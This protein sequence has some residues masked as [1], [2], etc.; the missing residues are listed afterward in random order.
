MY[1]NLHRKHRLVDLVSEQHTLKIRRLLVCIDR[2]MRVVFVGV[3]V[4]N[5]RT[6][7]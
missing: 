7:L 4:L 5:Y 2:E 6:P 1:I 3:G